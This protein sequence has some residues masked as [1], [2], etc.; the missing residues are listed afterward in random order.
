L[1]G[2]PYAKNRAGVS[3]PAKLAGP[4]EI[5]VRA[6]NH[7]GPGAR[8]VITIRLRA[9]AIQSRQ[10]AVR[11][12]LEN[13]P[14]AVRPAACCGSVKVPVDAQGDPPIVGAIREVVEGRELAIQRKP[15]ERARV[16][17]S[18]VAGCS[19]EGAVGASTGVPGYCPSAQSGWGQKLYSVVSVPSGS[20][21]GREW[22]CARPFAPAG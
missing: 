17:G 15:E 4:V 7:R 21:D 11:G 2:W 5:S 13:R 3:G 19:V 20:A 12:D 22:R 6:L 10:V 18:V 9:K 14:L 8:T 16:E 1:T